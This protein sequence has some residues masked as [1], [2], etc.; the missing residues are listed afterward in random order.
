MTPLRP[1]AL[2][3][4]VALAAVAARGPAA[5]TLP[6]G[7]YLEDA[8][9]ATFNQ[10]VAAAF[11]PDGRMFV[12]EKRGMVWVVVDGVRQ[13]E[14]WID[15]RAEVLNSHD[16]GLLG[17]AVDPAFA[18]NRRVYLSYTVDHEATTDQRRTDA[19]ARVIRVDGRADD[20]NRAD[21]S[22]RRVLLGETFATGIPSCYLSH[23]IGSLAVG[24]DGTL[25]VSTGDGAHY[26]RVDDGGEYPG[27]FGP[28][29]L[30]ASEDIGSFRSQ[31][32]ESLA[33]KILRIDAE[34]GLGLASNPFYT[35]RAA[36]NASRVWALG[37]RNPYRFTLVPDGAADPA[38]GDPGTL[39]VGDVGWKLWEDLDVARGG[40]NFGWPCYEGDGPNTE[41]QNARPATNGCGG[42]LAGD[43]TAPRYTWHHRTASLS[44]PSGRTGRALVVGAKVESGRYPAFWNDALFYS[45]YG[46]GWTSAAR[47][48]ASGEPVQERLFSADTG[49][50]VGMAFDGASG[51][52]H[53][54]DIG[55]GK[56]RR[57]RH[58]DERA[59]TPPLARATAL[60][61]QG[62]VGVSVQLSPE[63]SSDP[64]G[65]AL[66]YAWTFS[67]GATSGERVP[68]KVFRTAGDQW[69]E[70]AVSDGLA[71]TRT[72]ATVRVRAGGPPTIEIASP[73]VDSRPEVGGRVELRARVSDPDQAPGTLSIR[74]EVDQVHDAHVH[75]DVFVGSGAVTSFS[76]PEHGAPGERVYY[77]VRALVRD[78]SGLEAEASRALFL[79]GDAGEQDVA[80]GARPL[81][82]V[83]R[84]LGGGDNLPAIVDGVFPARGSVNYPAQYDSYTDPEGGREEDWVGLDLGA[85]RVLTRVTFQE[86]MHNDNGGWWET[87]R[88]Q[89]RRGGLWRDVL[90][91]ESHPAYRASDTVPFDTYELSFLPITGDAVRLIG[92]P[93]G[94]ST[95]VSVGELRAWAV[96]GE[97]TGGGVPAPWV[98]QTVGAAAPGRATAAAG[99]WS[100]EG[101]GEVWGAAD[102]FQFVHRPLAAEGTLTAHVTTLSSA[103]DWAKAG[104][105][106]RA[107]LAP[108]A[109]YVGVVVSNLG[110][111]LQ[112][113][114]AAGEGS[115]GPVDLWGRRTPVWLRLARS[116]ASVTALVSDDGLTWAEVG[117]L[118]VPALADA[119]EAAAG[120]AVSAADLTRSR[121]VQA[122]F[123][124][125][126]LA[127]SLPAPWVS[128]DIGAPVAS[129]ATEF[130]GGAF[131]VRGGGEV[132]GSRDAFQFAYQRLS[133]DGSVV[134]RLASREGEAE[135]AKA[136]LMV[137]RGTGDGAA[138]AALV[139]SR[140]GL[141]LQF[142]PQAG[143]PSAGPVDVWG[144][145]APRWLRL[146]RRGTTVAAFRSD[147]GADWQP[148]GT[149]EVP[150]LGTGAVLIGLMASAADNGSG[151]EASGV[152]ESVSV[153]EGAAGLLSKDLAAAPVGFGIDR[154]F[155]NPARS[156]ASVRATLPEDGR[157]TLEA[158][159]VLGR[160]IA[161][162]R[163]DATAGVRDFGLDLGDA[164][165]GVYTVRLR[166]EPTG[167]TSTRRLTVVR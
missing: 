157:V 121:T 164:P 123:R 162:V 146:D 125:V 5:Q 155:P 113:R 119:P 21:P 34:T 38:A 144:D 15:L 105:L 100:V 139:M 62:G 27:C 112:G 90:G 86:G 72:R 32:L 14:P 76:P 151:R 13:A 45:D 152:F 122:T 166:H 31:R 48:D 159:D 67:D 154:V 24:S 118:D 1:L 41:Y 43:L 59:N 79:A 61:A 163:L 85:E 65:D 23:T 165:A 57:L 111:H 134:A 35:G 133:G 89:V 74:W 73:S 92:R 148:V 128:A 87:L 136:G 46:Y 127:Q 150:G 36:D 42:P 68:V 131:R 66:T 10:P 145:A 17:I 63:G 135:W 75:P 55:R 88:V 107:G 149:V 53:M 52:L 77:R 33:G 153:G 78:A 25:L 82:L 167:A 138:N 156:R 3:G 56:I 51:Y 96:D 117:T 8:T 9:G 95:Y 4:L 83:P 29:R 147:D 115:V 142:R 44:R 64:D 99:A 81:A 108:E 103:P 6:S 60:P 37:V 110:V 47:L 69:A 91:L 40:E 19:Y 58:R 114:L 20:P 98:S 22:T 141:H 137:R 71:T 101:G 120:L 50:I 160:Q 11:A 158:L 94:R 161:V 102:G 18:A 39:Y 28:G 104:L 12:V 143:Q 54:V 80:T 129:G 49:F 26:G 16:R 126:S 7:F 116:G 130:S 2:V 97:A 140:L 30:P 132:W 124:D 93:G 84:S 109:P 70:L 106:I